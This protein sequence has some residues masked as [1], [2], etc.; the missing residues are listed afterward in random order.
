METMNIERNSE[1][2]VGNV[3]GAVGTAVFIGKAS[4][5]M[6]SIDQ[7]DQNDALLVRETGAVLAQGAE[8]SASDIEWFSRGEE[9]VVLSPPEAIPHHVPDV[10]GYTESV[11]YDA[12]PGGRRRPM[13][14][15]SLAAALVLGATV[16]LS[17]QA[18]M[19]RPG[20]SAPAPEALAV[21]AP[22]H[23]T[24]PPAMPTTMAMAMPTATPPTVVPSTAIWTVNS[25]REPNH[26][27]RPVAGEHPRPARV[28]RRTPVVASPARPDPG[29][30]IDPFATVDEAQPAP[31][32]A[33]R[34]TT[35]K[36]PGAG[37]T[38]VSLK[39]A[40]AG[41]WVDPFAE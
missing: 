25:G 10:D 5:R 33:V 36:S 35:L 34:A 29:A 2:Q 24:P 16:T 20:R 30:W 17:A 19:R 11:G 38:A 31:G 6:T 13:P 3:G 41:N 28:M 7:I 23:V 15:W 8:T 4:F 18:V 27:P 1:A 9:S 21:A 22:P 32:A 37:A 12:R 14:L 39:R 40:P 26:F